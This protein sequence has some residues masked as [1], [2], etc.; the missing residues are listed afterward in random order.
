MEKCLYYMQNN[1]LWEIDIEKLSCLV[2]S[3]C[4]NLISG[5]NVMIYRHNL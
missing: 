4:T 2:V 5:I 1:A 3:T